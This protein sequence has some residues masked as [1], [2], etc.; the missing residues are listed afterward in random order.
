MRRENQ[1]KSREEELQKNYDEYNSYMRMIGN[2][3]DKQDSRNSERHSVVEER[4][5][6]LSAN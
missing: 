5:S 3:L 2:V 4:P 1:T 6:D